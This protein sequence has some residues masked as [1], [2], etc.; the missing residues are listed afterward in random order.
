M[1]V[2][3]VFVLLVIVPAAAALLSES[4]LLSRAAITPAFD[5]GAL[6]VYSRQA[7]STQPVSGARDIRPSERGEF[8]YYNLINYLRVTDVLDDGRVLAIACNN[9]RLC[10]S[11]GD[12]DFRKARLTER[13]IH[14]R[15][16]P[17]FCA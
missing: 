10:F 8:Y 6:I 3:F 16:F 15:R 17:H 4:S 13:L 12:S 7:I 14:R 5:V 11:P 1:I 9:M 2:L